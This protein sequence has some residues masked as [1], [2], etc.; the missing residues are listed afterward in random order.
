MEV[1]SQRP[2]PGRGGVLIRGLGAG[3]SPTPPRAVTGRSKATTMVEAVATSGVPGAGETERTARATEGEAAAMGEARR[4]VRL[5]VS[6][7]SSSRGGS[8][9]LTGE[10]A[11]G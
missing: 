7:A 1:V 9:R 8:R 4:G 10:E 2:L 6:R 5:P 11:A 3:R